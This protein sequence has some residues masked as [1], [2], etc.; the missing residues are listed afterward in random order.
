MKKENKREK[1]IQSLISLKH[2]SQ[3]IMNNELTFPLP[4]LDILLLAPIDL[5][6]FYSDYQ[7]ILTSIKNLESNNQNI[8]Q[9]LDKFPA[10][11]TDRYESSMF[12]RILLIFIAFL[13]FFPFG[14]YIYYLVLARRGELKLKL[15]EIINNSHHIVLMIKDQDMGE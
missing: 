3:N 7:D 1:L 5:R 2:R 4:P 13:F 11:V 10:L 6:T 15:K 14:I 12:K 8:K 9:V